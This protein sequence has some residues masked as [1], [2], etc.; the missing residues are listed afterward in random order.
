MDHTWILYI[1]TYKYNTPSGE[2]RLFVA[3]P[4]NWWF[5]PIQ[6]L[7]S[8]N[9]ITSPQI[10]VNI[11][12]YLK[13][14]PSIIYIPLIYHL[15]I[16]FWWLYI[17]ICNIYIYIYISLI[18]IY[19]FYAEPETTTTLLLKFGLVF[20]G[21]F[22]LL[23]KSHGSSRGFGCSVLQTKTPTRDASPVVFF[24]ASSSWLT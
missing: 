22:P 15:Y 17:Y 19:T 20:Q 24:E 1:D 4:S 5:Q 14:P 6:K 8:S 10:G 3:D 2:S 13:P 21:I 18:Y 12:K 23:K 9:W 7:C 16:A 11:K